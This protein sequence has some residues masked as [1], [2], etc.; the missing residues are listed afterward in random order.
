M[1]RGGGDGGGGGGGGGGGVHQG[2]GD[3]A[4]VGAGGSVGVGA[5]VG[6][7]VDGGGGG[8]VV[9]GAV[10]ALALEGHTFKAAPSA[11]PDTLVVS[12]TAYRPTSVTASTNPCCPFSCGWLLKLC[13]ET[14][15][16]TSGKRVVASMVARLSA[17]LGTVQ[18]SSATASMALSLAGRNLFRACRRHFCKSR[19]NLASS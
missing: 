14:R 11:N 4:R 18:T 12:R 1:G 6:V 17:E 9:V 15:L 3:A 19:S 5:G 2:G 7:G 8:G 10:V 13:K 16:P